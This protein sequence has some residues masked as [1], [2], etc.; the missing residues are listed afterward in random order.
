MPEIKKRT[1]ETMSHASPECSTP[2]ANGG[3]IGFE[4]SHPSKRLCTDPATLM[5]V[6][7][8]AEVSCRW[9]TDY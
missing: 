3:V 6:H 9:T 5:K 1:F 4:N 8:S 2:P 7:F